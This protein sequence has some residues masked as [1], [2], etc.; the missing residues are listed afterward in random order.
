MLAGSQAKIGIYRKNPRILLSA[1]SRDSVSIE[2]PESLD[3]VRD[4]L[5]FWI[6]L[7]EFKL[8]LRAWAACQLDLL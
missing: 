2:D 8:R 1:T 4:L 6:I 7:V 5:G 3:K